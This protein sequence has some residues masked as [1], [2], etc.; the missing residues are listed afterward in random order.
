M[1]TAWFALAPLMVAIRR[2]RLGTALLL[3]WLWTLGAT[4]AI[5]D[6]FPRA[7]TEYFRQPFGSSIALFFLVLTTMA[8]PY[9][10]VFAV[11]YRQLARRPGW[12]FSFLTAA[13]WVTA[14]LGRGRLFTGTPFFIGNPW[15]LIGY[16]QTDWLPMSQIASLTGVYGVSFAL[17]CVNAAIAETWLV[18]RASGRL[19]RRDFAIF[20]LAC[21]PAAGSLGYGVTVLAA[22]ASLTS[23]PTP[24]A[25]AQTNLN[26]GTRW[27]SDLY[28]TNLDVYLQLTVRRKV[29][30]RRRSSSGRR[31]R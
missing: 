5:G 29:K 19:A 3:T 11:L 16:S 22:D 27:R 8:A 12:A 10:M 6:W 4:Y 21:L 20:A 7:V 23:E 17:L 28:G 15:G 30:E 31:R 13:A 2:G 1:S 18:Y 14:E 24:I 25:I 26:L 9:Y